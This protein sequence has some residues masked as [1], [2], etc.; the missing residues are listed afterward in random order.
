MARPMSLSAA[1]VALLATTGPALA[2]PAHAASDH[3]GVHSTPAEDSQQA[4]RSAAGL[5]AVSRRSARPATAAGETPLT[6]TIDQLTPSTI[7]TEGPVRVAGTV[8]NT[9]DVAWR[10]INV[11]SFVS[12]DPMTTT[13]ALT[14]A[15][16]TDP[17]VSV[18]ERIIEP[19]NYDTI[20]E[21]APG[22]SAAFSFRVARRLLEADA[23]G[24]YWFG[25]HALGESTEG[26]DGLA[27]GR[28]RTFLPYVPPAREGRVEV[29]VV[30]PLRRQLT[31]AAD[32]SLAD[33]PAWTT[34]LSTG[35][36]LRSLVD[37]GDASG[38]Q[39]VSWVVDPA[40]LD[41]VRRVADG[42]PPRSLAANLERGQPDGEDTED[43]EDPAASG[44]PGTPSADESAN[45][46]QEPSESAP[47]D[48]E[49][50]VEEPPRELTAEEQAA[51]AAARAWL[52]R[53]RGAMQPE[54]QVLALPYGDLDVAAA[55]RHDP[56]A[57]QRA[58][59]RSGGVLEELGLLTSPVVASP[60]GYLNPLGLRAVETDA[61]VLVTD[62]MFGNR[63]PVVATAASRR[64][65]VA[66]SGA[67]AG[68]PGPDDPRSVLA[69]R[70]RL[71]SEASVRVLTA[72]RPPVVALLPPDWVPSSGSTFFTG[73]DVPWLKLASLQRATASVQPRSVTV[74]QLRYPPGQATAELDAANFDSAQ[75]LTTAGQALQNLLT[76]NNLVGATVA[77]QAMGSTSYSA[78]VRPN[79][80]RAANDESREWIEERLE[81]VTVRAP[82]A[83]TLSS[84]SGRFGTTI[85]NELDQPV[86]VSLEAR[87]DDRLQIEAEPRVEVP[88][89][90]RATVLLNARTKE[91]GI[92][93]VTLVVTDKKGNPLGGTTVLSIR[94]AQVSNVIWLFIGLGG[95][96]LFGAIIVRVVRSVRSTVGQHDHAEQQDP[97]SVSDDTSA[98]AGASAR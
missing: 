6:V 60:A 74:E 97:D 32:G 81:K 37:F 80:A 15:V 48:D 34:A 22:E 86:T 98:P 14:A 73:L 29:A 1:L 43:S 68:G 67:M 83:V 39:P 21:I 52:G 5:A 38:D 44:A 94:S 77:D 31:Y 87:S 13:D 19:R 57:Y 45:P 20:E 23:P 84:S 11:Y 26:R 18:G 76:L 49:P 63:P 79:A 12:A 88:A 56:E 8:T 78:R 93:R 9:D 51:A 36:R 71:L 41:A 4:A 47:P 58:R 90:G 64:L 72:R 92:H 42:N 30:V 65:V 59:N 54:D 25:V 69:V 10:S 17:E 7:P 46:S 66:S 55:G 91:N 96:L 35:G 70:Q 27:D 24:V 40:L 89:N 33:L 53:L 2:M 75:E 61:T 16:A 82:V 95:F 28:A 85:R 62:A 50:P 3:T